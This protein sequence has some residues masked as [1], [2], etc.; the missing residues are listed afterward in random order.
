VPVI[1]VFLVFQRH[2]VQGLT[3]GAIKG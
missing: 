1:A 2:F 3:A